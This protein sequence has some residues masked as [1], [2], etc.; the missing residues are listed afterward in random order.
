M[1]TSAAA[2]HG[3]KRSTTA[4]RPRAK[5]PRPAAPLAPPA[6]AAAA[7]PETPAGSPDGGATAPMHSTKSLAASRLRDD[8][9]GKQPDYRRGAR[10]NLICCNGH[11]CA[12]VI[13]IDTAL[14]AA[15]QRRQL[16][17][18]VFK[19]RWN[20]SHWK[21]FLC[22]RCRCR[23][24]LHFDSAE[25]CANCLYSAAAAADPAAQPPR[26]VTVYRTHFAVDMYSN[27]PRRLSLCTACV[28][29][30]AHQ[31]SKLIADAGCDG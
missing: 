28:A 16:Q 23:A 12:G 27:E 31:F 13:E 8:P 2:D 18:C 1:D 7:E 19:P 25:H 9:L 15:A 6:A 20:W 17:A 21:T 22:A 10:P 14:P 30:R 5:K 26:T 4:R 11:G 29:E 24:T 3:T